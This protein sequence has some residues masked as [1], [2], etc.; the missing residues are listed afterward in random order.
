MPKFPFQFPDA[1]PPWL[2]AWPAEGE[3]KA[4]FSE[5]IRRYCH[6]ILEQERIEELHW[7]DAT[8]VLRLGH[9]QATWRLT[10][11][12]WT[13]QCTCGYINDRCV[14]LYAAA[15]VLGEILH[16]RQA[17][18]KRAPRGTPHAGRTLPRPAR[19]RRA[20]RRAAA[21][22]H[23]AQQPPVRIEVEADFHHDPLRVTLR[24]YLNEAGKRRLLRM[25]QLLNLAVRTKHEDR[26]RST[27]S[28]DDRNLLR[29]LAAQ[30]P[31]GSAAVRQNLTVLKVPQKRFEYWTEHWAD[32]P[33]RF[34]ER[35][36]QKALHADGKAGRLKIE[37][38]D[39][40]EWVGVAAVI[41]TP[42]GR[43]FRVDEVFQM[44]ASGKRDLVLDG[45]M[46]EFDSPLAWDTISEVFSRKARRMR[47]EHV[48][49]HLPNLLEGRLDIVDGP[50]VQRRKEPAPVV[51]RARP[52][53]ADVLLSVRVG[54]ATLYPDSHAVA[55]KISA[56]G[57]QFVITTYDSPA[58]RTVRQFLRQLPTNN[59]PD[60]VSRLAGTV[61][62]INRLVS[63]WQKLPAEIERE[64]APD[65]AELLLRP[66]AIEPQ[67]S[68]VDGKGHVD[69][70]VDWSCGQHAVTDSELDAAVTAGSRVLRTRGGAWLQISP[71]RL[72][73]VREQLQAAG[74]DEQGRQ[75]LFRPE[76]GALIGELTE[77]LPELELPQ[78]DRN[79]ADRL[80]AP[81]EPTVELPTALRSVLR[82]YQMQGFEFL[83]DRCRYGLG[84][85]L[86]DDM[87]LGKT[88]Q[89]LALL[90]AHQQDG[91]LSAPTQRAPTG[92][93][94]QPSGALIICPA[95]VVSVW[96]EQVEQFCPQLGC[97]A[98]AGPPEQ[99]REILADGAWDM[100]VTNYAVARN[101]AQDLAQHHFRFVVLDE[102]Q[103][104][105]NPE[106]RIAQV[107]KQLRTD[108][109]LALTG[110]PLEN[111][112]LDLWSIMDFANP[113]FLGSQDEFVDGYERPQRR[114]DL[115]TRVAPVILRR[116]K[117][118]VAPELPPRTEEV[119]T[120]SMDEQQRAVYD[121]ELLRAREVVRE[122][123]PIEILAALT[124][125]RQICCDPRLVKN[126]C[127]D[128]RSTKVDTL[129]DM[130]QEIR[131]E[132]HS[133]L[134]FSQFT[135]MLAL[136]QKAMHDI[137][138]LTITGDTPTPRRAELVRE[139]N[140]STD[141]QVFLL[142][143][144]AAGTGLTL[145]KA[146]YVFI[147][148]PWWNPAVER[149]AIDRT[150]RIGQD[151]P[152]FAYRLVTADTVEQNVLTLQREKAEMFDQVMSPTAEAAFPQSLTA[153]DLQRL[154]T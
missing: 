8:L 110:T 53:G 132:G 49:E 46:L 139:F 18:P 20:S 152:V 143:L 41:V 55:G 29:W 140:G 37:L 93:K 66:A 83:M 40:G 33:G 80:R 124:R 147:Y 6:R 73:K 68:V 106:S 117:E 130:V 137:P 129:L 95:S 84:P 91:R 141:P 4:L 71:E 94:Q 50:I 58:I 101:D 62:N 45:E 15:R 86:A 97:I 89:V 131:D 16:S 2:A 22:P 90:T 35:S 104:I 82:P 12:A 111:R 32:C 26:A 59:E 114:K 24:F 149:Q 7:T 118:A 1:L 61:S 54:S 78:S 138:T 19:E 9:Q 70:G 146:D 127:P 100:I 14:H 134:V 120:V 3:I 75:R 25:Q 99:R 31:S 113:A 42:R 23:P 123:G 44:L 135:S 51:L 65:L 52:D 56:A 105:K 63:E 119:I 102:A 88:L 112:L 144:R 87:G 122:K 150:H 72:A 115:S 85:I 30:L 107:V 96:L 151:K 48:C 11:G 77:A 142:S 28:R 79:V 133:I 34:I 13:R 67:L 27:W 153:A 60:G 74:F 92:G 145:T 21:E 38:T 76:A 43:Q 148:D 103:H 5:G 154:L 136:I 109:A 17:P 64:V 125:L 108:H 121:A 39:Q 126:A 10:D 69:L 81:H 128:A 47:R 36:S 98:Y 57:K 116:T